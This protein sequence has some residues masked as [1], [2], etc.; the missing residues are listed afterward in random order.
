MKLWDLIGEAW[1][2]ALAQRTPTVTVAILAAAMCLATLL[3][4]GRSAHAEQNVQL[5]LEDAGSRVL[6]VEST[7]P[8]LDLLTP[9]VTQAVAALSVTDRSIATADPVDVVPSALAGAERTPLWWARGE[10]PQVVR[11]VDGRWPRA[12]EAIVSAEVAAAYGLDGPAGALA[13]TGGEELPVVGLFQPRHPF[14]VYASGSLAPAAESHQMSSITVVATD[15][16]A[17][18]RLEA[19]VLG[20]IDPPDAQAVRV[21]SPATLADVQQ[22]VGADLTRFSRSL[23]VLV[24]AT[25][26][27]LTAV[28]VLADTLVRQRDLGRRRALGADRYSI[29]A[30]VTARTTMAASAGTLAG[31]GIAVAVGRAALPP[32]HFIA[33]VVVLT[34]VTASLASVSL[35]LLAAYRDPVAVLRTP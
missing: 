14:D 12:G 5:A 30:L 33:G 29:V 32:P 10:L 8:A 7:R 21:S 4:V 28:V 17:A 34:V 25:G 26:G 16:S 18:P 24:L 6:A 19:S 20:L 2:S 11:L 15:A 1:K 31:T 27:A 23:L 13:T 35:A 22:A 3:T 9:A